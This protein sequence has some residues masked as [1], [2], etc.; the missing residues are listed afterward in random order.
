MHAFG[1]YIFE[2]ILKREPS[3]P[4]INLL[5]LKRMGRVYLLDRASSSV[6]SF[7]HN[8]NSKTEKYSLVKRNFFLYLLNA[9]S[10][11]KKH[12]QLPIKNGKFLFFVYDPPSYEQKYDERINEWLE[13][14]QTNLNRFKDYLTSYKNSQIEFF[15]FIYI[16]S[17]KPKNFD[18]FNDKCCLD[19]LYFWCD[20]KNPKYIEMIEK[21]NNFIECFSTEINEIKEETW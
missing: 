15:E 9:N 8:L 20:D 14:Y 19:N 10:K 13:K 1:Y 2:D 5:F 6:M 3:N 17:E 4:G 7:Y 16:S 11:A 12:F 18:E 21:L